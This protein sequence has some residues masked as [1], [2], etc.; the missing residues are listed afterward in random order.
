[1]NGKPPVDFFF[2]LVDD[3]A[4]DLIYSETMRYATQYLQ[5]N[6]EYLEGHPHARAHEWKNNPLTPKEIEVFISLMIAM[7]ICGFPSI[8]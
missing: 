8:R 5:K 2:Q 7:G 6:T 1:M 4:M 3:R